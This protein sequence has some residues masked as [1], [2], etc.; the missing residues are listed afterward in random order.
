MKRAFFASSLFLISL[1][2]TGCSH[3]SPAAKEPAPTEHGPPLM[4]N[5]QLAV[6]AEIARELMQRSFMGEETHLEAKKL[7]SDDGNQRILISARGDVMCSPTG[8]CPYWIFQKTDKGYEEEVDIGV[9]QS[10][11]I[12]KS[13]D[14]KYP[15]LK[16]RQHG[17]ATESEER[18]YQFDG[19]HY[20]LT[21]CSDLE[22]QDPNDV[23]RILD[24]PVI[25]EIQCSN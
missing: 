11:D 17:S 12:T 2:A 1:T 18:T 19:S 10:V 23:E 7:T 3:S 5:D 4:S 16:V 9:A 21:K 15:T 20:R 24:K 25:T 6:P 14:E 13:K 8:N 22:Y